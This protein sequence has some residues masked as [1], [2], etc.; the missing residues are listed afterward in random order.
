MPT[1]YVVG[2]SGG[3]G[4]GKTSFVRELGARFGEAATLIS[5]DEYY[6]PTH[7]QVGDERGVLNFDLPGSID[8]AAM[9]ADLRR[10][11]AG[12]TVRRAE[13]MF[14]TSYT[15]VAIDHEEVPPQREGGVVEYRPAPILIVE[16]LFVFHERA[17][18]DLLDLRVFIAAPA[19]AMFGR[20]I[21]RDRTERGLPLEDVL[22]RYEGHVY[23]S[24]RTYVEPHAATAHLVVNN[25]E[26][27]AP[28]LEVLASH[29]RSKLPRD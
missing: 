21:K 27:F 3:S 18:R 15:E 19:V 8:A 29:L 10:V 12:E 22:Y 9:A 26:S 5:A 14:E 24:F 6:R 4:S 16:G 28:G 25:A 11:I 13:Y 1:P 7:E 17:L 23:P 20:R 2:V